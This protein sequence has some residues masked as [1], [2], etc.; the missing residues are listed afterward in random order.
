MQ[1]CHLYSCYVSIWY[2]KV[3]TINLAILYVEIEK[4]FF[5]II[6]ILY[7]LSM[8]IETS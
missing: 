2:G 1:N 8:L 6:S 3:K 4:Q 5:N 7:L